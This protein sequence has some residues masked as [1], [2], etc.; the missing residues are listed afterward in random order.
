MEDPLPS[1]R[2]LTHR[3]YSLMLWYIVYFLVID[4]GLFCCTNRNKSPSKSLCP[5]VYNRFTF[6]SWCVRK[7]IYKNQ[8][9]ITKVRAI[10]SYMF[11]QFKHIRGVLQD[12]Q[13]RSYEES[14]KD[15]SEDT[16]ITSR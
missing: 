3:Q 8:E 6:H 12:T 7:N 14:E 2:F 16:V 13:T 15:T 4:S 5:Q 1:P 9:R 11:K 10:V